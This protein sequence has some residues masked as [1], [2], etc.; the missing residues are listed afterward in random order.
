MS[1]LDT[2]QIEIP[3]QKCKFKNPVLIRQIV[4][5]DTIICR[6]CRRNIALSDYL[7]LVEKARADYERAVE[8]LK[9]AL[10]KEIKI[11]FKF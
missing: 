4:A 3:C 1:D 7:K 8:D 10:N 5:G 9:D 2:A 11:D 6:G